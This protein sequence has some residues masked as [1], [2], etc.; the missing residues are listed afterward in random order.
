VN[1]LVP[2]VDDEPDVAA[3]VRRQFR[4]DLRAQRFVM[5]FA[6]S[7]AEALSRISAT[8]EQHFAVGPADFRVDPHRSWWLSAAQGPNFHKAFFALTE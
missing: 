6:N 4:K 1:V 3:L 8:I 5:E 2:V 7:A